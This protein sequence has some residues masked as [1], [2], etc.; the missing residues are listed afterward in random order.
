[1]RR[2]LRLRHNLPLRI[3]N[4]FLT[5]T[6][7]LLM[8]DRRLHAPLLGVRPLLLLLAHHRALIRPHR[9]HR[10]RARVLQ[11]VER[12]GARAGGLG[13]A[14]L[15]AV[16]GVGGLA[17]EAGEVA[18][19]DGFEGR[20]AG[21]EN[22]DVGFDHAPVHGRRDGPGG[23]GVDEHLRDEGDADDGGDAGA[24]GSV[25]GL[26]QGLLLGGGLTIGLGRT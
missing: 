20:D 16:G 14:P 5:P 3:D 6:L 21:R 2:N 8:L 25:G 19:R 7:D 24:R 23:V 18:L 17:N 15:V 9:V 22:A 10:I 13:G 1:M 4:P 12:K 11:L 26:G